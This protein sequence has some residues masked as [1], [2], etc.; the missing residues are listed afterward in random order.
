MVFSV[1][2]TICK[3]YVYNKLIVLARHNYTMYKVAHMLESNKHTRSY[4]LIKAWYQNSTPQDIKVL[5]WLLQCTCSTPSPLHPPPMCTCLAKLR[6]GILCV[7]GA[8]IDSRPPLIPTPPEVIEFTYCHDIFP[9]T[10]HNKKVTKYN[11]VITITTDVRGATNDQ[12][13]NYNRESNRQPL[14]WD[15]GICPSSSG[16]LGSSR[17]FIMTFRV[18]YWET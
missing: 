17:T 14:P 8:P 6:L 1:A 2:Y 4:T 11:P 15:L 7:L 10:A 16:S 12:F 3:D 18:V 13:K 9:N 5:Q